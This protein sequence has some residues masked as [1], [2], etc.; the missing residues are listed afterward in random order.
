MTRKLDESRSSAWRIF[1]TTYTK[2]IELIER[3]L[4]EADLPSLGWYDVLLALEEAPEHRLR[5]HELAE[6]IV[7]SRSNLT[8]LVD[9]LEAESLLYRESCPT[10]RRGAFAVITD[11]GLALRHRMWLVYAQ[12]IAEHFACY[13]SD[14]EVSLL[15][16][17]LKR[18]LDKNYEA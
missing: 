7:L 1:I 11:K 12:S 2:V 15:A 3:D 5:M 14:T 6:F 18:V 16:K 17:A 13:L 8:R 4:A 10:D 9:R